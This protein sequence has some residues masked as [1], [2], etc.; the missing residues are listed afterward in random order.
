MDR[1][2]HCSCFQTPQWSESGHEIPRLIAMYTACVCYAGRFHMHCPHAHT[3]ENIRTSWIIMFVI[4][5]FESV[6]HMI[7][8]SLAAG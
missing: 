6:G 4:C 7:L 8:P 2:K 5:V 3:T 1:S